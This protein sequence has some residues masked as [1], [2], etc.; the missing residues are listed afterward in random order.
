M[1]V[2]TEGPIKATNMQRPLSAWSMHPDHVHRMWPK[3]SLIRLMCLAS[4]LKS[5]RRAKA[6]YI[7]KL[8]N[9]GHSEQIIKMLHRVKVRTTQQ[10]VD[11]KKLKKNI[12]W[13]PHAYHKKLEGANKK[14]LA[15]IHNSE[16]LKISWDDAFE[17]TSLHP[18]A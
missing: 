4:D 17:G 13:M 12:L 1:K 6:M 16:G 15:E 10:K 18:E 5:A 2:S 3:A 11:K 8:R 9:S 7:T 14:A